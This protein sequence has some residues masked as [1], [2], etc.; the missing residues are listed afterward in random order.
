MATANGDQRNSR[1]EVF[2]SAAL[3]TISTLANRPANAAAAT[4]GACPPGANNCFSTESTEAKT[5]IPVWKWPSG[6]SRDEAI[7][8]LKATVET[9][10]QEGQ[11]GVDNGGWTYA[12][13]QLADTGYARLE[14]KSGIGKFAKFFNGGKPFVDDLEFSVQ[15]GEVKVKSTSR[16]GDSDFGVNGK[17]LNFIAGQLRAKGWDASGP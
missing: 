11:N 1:R 10:P 9:Y 6:M 2:T 12:V 16:V 8:S 7:A 15:S 3:L 14:F 5:K 13:D 17:R 4:V